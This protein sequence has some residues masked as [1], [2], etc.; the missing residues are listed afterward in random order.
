M[1]AYA[2]LELIP[3]GRFLSKDEMVNLNP[4]ANTTD[5]NNNN[6]RPSRERYRR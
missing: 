3:P 5:S 6:P 4:K 2:K 1:E